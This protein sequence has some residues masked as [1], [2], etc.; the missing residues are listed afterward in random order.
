MNDLSLY[1]PPVRRSS[2]LACNL[3]RW[4]ATTPVPEGRSLCR[5]LAVVTIRS[6]SR[7]EDNSFVS[8]VFGRSRS[9][10]RTQQHELGVTMDG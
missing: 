9:D 4:T 6:V 1:V 2:L 5:A 8:V 10:C 7:A 3:D